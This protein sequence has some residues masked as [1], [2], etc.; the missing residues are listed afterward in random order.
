MKR[1]TTIALTALS[2]LIFM[3]LGAQAQYYSYQQNNN[4]DQVVGGLLGAGLGAIAG[5]QLAG[6]GARTEG[7][8][9]G[10]VVGG[11]A[12]AALAN[13]NSN[14]NRSYY[15]TPSQYQGRTVYNP[16]RVNYH[17]PRVVRTQPRYYQPPRVRHV[18]PTYYHQPRVRHVQPTYYQQ[19]RTH[20]TQPA[21]RYS[22]PR[23]YQQPRTGVSNR[24][25]V[26]GLVGGSLGSVVGRQIAGSGNRT[27][28]AIIGGLVGGVAGTAFAGRTQPSYGTSYV[29]PRSYSHTPSFNSYSQPRHGG[30]TIRVGNSWNGGHA[31]QSNCPSGTF[32]TR[33]ARTGATVCMVR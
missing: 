19:P 22:Q 18:Q 14:N 25:V 27:E 24:Q 29:Q 15:T 7:S 31:T 17:Q 2:A 6:N 32:Q 21:V 8:V 9:L 1:S 26:G 3:P 5:S 30:S 23:H 20:Y 4:N 28:G 11:V 33:D 13:R 16:P 10:A 12:G